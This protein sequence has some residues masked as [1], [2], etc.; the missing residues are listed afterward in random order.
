MS[1]YD[2]LDSPLQLM[3][4]DTVQQW[5]VAA[6]TAEQQLALGEKVATA[7]YSQGDGAR[8]ITYTPADLFRLRARIAELSAFLGVGRR[9]RAGPM[10]V[11]F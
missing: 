3:P 2:P 8:S 9:G 10:R 4:R 11:C 6:M 7:S 5:L 1:H